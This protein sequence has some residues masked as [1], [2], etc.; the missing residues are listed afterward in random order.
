MRHNSRLRA[1]ILSLG[2]TFV[3]VGLVTPHA[4]GAGYSATAKHFPTGK[5][6][7]VESA[8]RLAA[9]N[10]ALTQCRTDITDQKGYCD[11]IELGGKKLQTTQALKSTI[12][13]GHYPLYL[14]RFEKANS[15]V[16]LAGSIHLLK[17]GFYPLPRQYLEAFNAT[18]NLVLEVDTKKL[19]A[20][21]VQQKSLQYGSLAANQ[22]LA[23]VLPTHT[24]AALEKILL[25]Y[26]APISHFQQFKPNLVTQQLA[27]FALLSVGYNPEI[28]LESHF[29]SKAKDKTILELES[30]DFQLDLLLNAPMATQVEMANAMIDQMN[31]FEPF[32]ADLVSA[33]LRGDDQKFL[34]VTQV[35]QGDTDRL[36]AFHSA[37]IDK[38]NHSMA[39]TVIGYLNAG[40]RYFVLAGAAHLIGEQGIPTLLQKA[41]YVGHRIYSDHAIPTTNAEPSSP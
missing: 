8:N 18:D 16:Y 19:G 1:R 22:T 9:A 23:G 34:E 11:L 39:D 36:R 41:G 29:R 31:D 2:I 17:P 4:F 27:L 25:E 28:G 15:V 26:G 5:T 24:Y 37:L 7:K 32:T 35:Q 38:R 33:W 12:P 30:F 6:Y 14:W 3:L 20:L 13:T 21:E 40:G 10:T